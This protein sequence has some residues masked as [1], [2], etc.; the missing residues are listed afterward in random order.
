MRRSV[1]LSAILLFAFAEPQPSATNTV[2]NTHGLVAFWDFVQ[3]DGDSWTSY[4]DPDVS[5]RSF[6]VHLKRVGDTSAYSP[7]DWPYL[8][9]DSELVFDD[10][11]PFGHAVRFNQGFIY[12]AVERKEFDRTLLDLHGRRPWTII[13]W[14]KFIGERHMVAGIWDEGGW[15]A[16]AGRRQ[17][18]LFAGL[19]NQKG[20]IAHVSATGA[21]S[22]P[23]SAIPGAQYAR[24]RAIDRRAFDNDQWIAMAATFDPERGEVVAYLNGAMTQHVLSDP[25]TED[26]Y[27]HESEQAANPFRF[28]YPIYSPRAFV[29]KFNGYDVDTSSVNEHRLYIELNAGDVTYDRDERTVTSTT[30]YR[31]F[32]DVLRDGESILASPLEMKGVHGH[33]AALP[34][35]KTVREGDEISATLQA[36]E[37]DAWVQVGTN[38][39]AT[40]REGAPFTLGRALGLG[41][42][43]LGHGSQLFIDGV[44]V[45][46]RVLS[47][48]ELEQLS[49]GSER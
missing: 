15:D 19:F 17:V 13:A 30:A 24:L 29:V 33:K 10:S 23:Q 37:S 49:F 44:A 26:V 6:P 11:G 22:Y 45:F 34:P 12:G 42:D 32:V 20:V 2:A 31:V 25:V 27:R 46:N 38:V 48:D 43:E 35:G 47:R 39:R 18:A 28:D 40:V 1:L 36:R 21:A 7:S 41:S 5:E 4:F 8:D 14:C 9:D 16:Y 3:T